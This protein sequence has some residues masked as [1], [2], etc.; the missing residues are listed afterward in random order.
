MEWWEVALGYMESTRDEGDFVQRV[1]QLGQA[2]G[3]DNGPRRLPRDGPHTVMRRFR[4]SRYRRKSDD[5]QYFE[6]RGTCFP[7]TEGA[8]EK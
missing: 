6:S 4:F 1:S 7:P 5:V 8:V 2:G 3:Q